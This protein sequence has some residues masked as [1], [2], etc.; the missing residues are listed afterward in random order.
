MLTPG[1][2]NTASVHID[3]EEHLQ[4]RVNGYLVAGCN[5]AERK[6]ARSDGA[7]QEASRNDHNKGQDKYKA[8][9]HEYVGELSIQRG[10]KEHPGRD[11][12]VHSR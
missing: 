10:C 4:S 1:Q 3:M 9:V 7:Q 11:I 2:R 12:R 8:S 6:G 5:V